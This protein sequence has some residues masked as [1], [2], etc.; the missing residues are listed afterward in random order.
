MSVFSNLPKSILYDDI[1]NEIERMILDNTLPAGSKLPSE[2]ELATMLGVSRNIL[3]EALKTLKERGLISVKT[4]DGAYVEKPDP[5]VLHNVVR[6]LV[7]RQ[8][9][10][11]KDVFELRF[12]IEVTACSLAAE[13]AG[14]EDLREIES[15]IHEMEISTKNVARWVD[16][17][18]R[19]H[20]RIAESTKNPLF[21]AFIQPLTSLL[22]ELFE[23]GYYKPGAIQRGIEGHRNILESI[24]SKDTKKA[25][26][27]MAEHLKISQQLLHA[28]Q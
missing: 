15:L 22:S 28:V 14:K 19:F 27:A 16:V 3:R 23:Q 24:R 7:R 5:K 13:R 6:R 8:N 21:L 26:H 10:T 1:A 9:V 20:L 17:E 12:S 11:L 25:E 4:G 18:L 2:Q